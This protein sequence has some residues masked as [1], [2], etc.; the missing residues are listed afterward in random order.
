[1][2]MLLRVQSVKLLTTF[3]ILYG[4]QAKYF[5]DEILPTMKHT[6]KGTVA[7]ASA[8]PNLNGS[9]VKNLFLY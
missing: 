9:Q 4:E 7:M 6:K 1:M 3:R 2:G 5:Q 8:G